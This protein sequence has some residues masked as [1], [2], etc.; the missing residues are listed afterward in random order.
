[1]R[2]RSLGHR[3]QFELLY[4]S[5]FAI[6]EFFTSNHIAFL[7]IEENLCLNYLKRVVEMRSRSSD[8]ISRRLIR[9][10]NG[11]DQAGVLLRTHDSLA[12]VRTSN[13]IEQSSQAVHQW[14]Q[15]RR[16]KTPGFAGDSQ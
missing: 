16:T 8:L 15:F 12:V 7:D 9:E 11:R 13:T 6:L 14:E 2:M 3:C 4:L 10:F 1:M 5:V